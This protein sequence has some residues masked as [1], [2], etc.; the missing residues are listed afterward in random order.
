MSQ[1]IAGR[2]GKSSAPKQ[3]SSPTVERA[4]QQGALRKTAPEARNEMIAVLAYY[5]AERRAFAPG[6]ELEDWLDAEREV[7]RQLS[8]GGEPQH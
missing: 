5:R 4:G 1:Q 2:T 7:D 3:T 6:Q 8:G